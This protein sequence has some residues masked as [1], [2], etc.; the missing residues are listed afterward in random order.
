M[1][2]GSITDNKITASSTHSNARV[3]WG[4]LH[5]SLG[6]WTPN[7]DDSYQWF[8]VDFSPDVKLIS[9]IATQGN[10]KNWW[11]ADTYYV[12]YRTGDAALKEYK[13][14]N[15]KRVSKALNFIYTLANK[16]YIFHTVTV[17]TSMF[18][19]CFRSSEATLTRMM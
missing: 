16:S 17:L 15:E 14:N 7:T 19:S 13:E 8:Q 9:H 11:W 1:E 18:S 2:D 4:R 5:C 10:G 3:T 12:V 6:S